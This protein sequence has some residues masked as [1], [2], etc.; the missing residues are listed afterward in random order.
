[1]AGS[2]NSR[3][4]ILLMIILFIPAVIGVGLSRGIY[5]IPGVS[6]VSALIDLSIVYVA[7][8][9]IDSVSSMVTDTVISCESD[10]ESDDDSYSESDNDDDGFL[11]RIDIPDIYTFYPNQIEEATKIINDI[12]KGIRY[13][14]L[15]AQMQCG[16][17]GVYLYIA[18][19]ILEESYDKKKR[20]ENIII[21]TGNRD[22]SLKKQTN[23]D[24]DLA[25]ES[26]L[27]LISDIDKR[28]QLRNHFNTRIH[29][30]FGQDLEK[31]CHRE[32]PKSKGG[33]PKHTLIIWDEPHYAQNI[34]NC[35]NK[36]FFNYYGLQDVLEGNFK[37]LIRKNIYIID[38]GATS[39]SELAMDDKVKKGN[40]TEEELQNLNIGALEEKNVHIMKTPENYRGVKEFIE[41]RC[42]HFNAKQ[43]GNNNDNNHIRGILNDDFHSYKNK[44]ILIRTRGA[45]T[46]KD[47]MEEIASDCNYDYKWFFGAGDVHP[48]F[49]D[50][51]F[52]LLND[53]PGR[54]TIIHICGKARMGQVLPK[55]HIGMV[56]ESS[57]YPNTD[58][59][60]QG[61][62]GRMCGYHNHA[63]DI[64]ISDKCE[65][66]VDN[67][68]KFWEDGNL[69]HIQYT[70]KAMNLKGRGD[71]KY[72]SSDGEKCKDKD[73]N[74]WRKIVP[75]KFK[76]SDIE[77]DNG[78]KK[79]K[80]SDIDFN[81]M[82][83][84]FDTNPKL[85]E[86]DDKDN[87]IELLSRELAVRRD[88]NKD[89]YQ[90][91]GTKQKLQKACNE[92]IREVDLFT[93]NITKGNT[94]KLK[95]FQV[96]GGKKDAYLIGFVKWIGSEPKTQ[97]T[98]IIST[99]C[100]FKQSD[101]EQKEIVFTLEDKTYG[102]M[103]FLYKSLKLCIKKTLPD[104]VEYNPVMCERIHSNVV[105]YDEELDEEKH[106]SGCIKFDYK[107]KK[108]IK[109]IIKKLNKKYNIVIEFN[110]LQTYKKGDKKYVKLSS[111]TW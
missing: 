15:L 102:D 81:D 60:L 94:N 96:I 19:K 12:K 5:S 30:Y 64:Y 40:F 73:G 56:Y 110:N 6:G 1:M 2:M 104:N 29:I 67:Y 35:P 46:F 44:Y 34:W 41:K 51:Y 22:I 111:I 7:P 99:S 85:I 68:S 108:Q 77:K 54:P 36:H 87:I 3:F 79:I 86:C 57:N 90:K 84:L 59:I 101:C 93:N 98:P 52:D 72:T 70:K 69:D 11:P 33:I 21:I 76:L 37:E 107:H 47:T 105:E 18:F 32:F 20:V 23:G 78:G 83:N 26:Y 31:I 10:S 45:K 62:L 92:N 9:I 50:R 53:E 65:I 27:D 39:F 75:I 66:E 25:Q 43:I 61:L 58:T 100:V 42:I 38:V 48:D 17:T 71:S 28:K 97:S 49:K 63:I 8:A 95:P 14:M 55:K 13:T 74:W 88:I 103:D 24:K 80:I 4:F 109:K 82:I 106:V 91:R 89:T 16:K